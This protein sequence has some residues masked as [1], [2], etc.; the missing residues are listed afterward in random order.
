MEIFMHN[1]YTQIYHKFSVK[2]S[3]F[4]NKPICESKYVIYIYPSVR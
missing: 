4:D 2:L 1:I 3:K